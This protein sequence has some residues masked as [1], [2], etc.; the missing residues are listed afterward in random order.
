MKLPDNLPGFSQS[1]PAKRFRFRI[2]AGVLIGLLFEIGGYLLLRGDQTA[3]GWVMF[4]GV[5]TVMGFAI[6]LFT[7]TKWQT[8]WS[9]LATWALGLGFLILVRWEGWICCALAT[10]LLL[11][12]A[13]LGAMIGHNV[14]AWILRGNIKIIGKYLTLGLGMIFLIGAKAIE[15]PHLKA[16]LEVFSNTVTVSATPEKAWDLIKSIERVE[17][18]KPLLLAIGLPVPQSCTLDKEGVGGKRICYFDQ[19]IIAQKLRNG[20]LRTT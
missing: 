13:L 3:F 15:E 20:I 18:H 9:I 6:A 4:T 14:R 12:C 10:P 19:G 7:T 11:L 5:P 1:Q 2:L 8:F 17:T 16:R